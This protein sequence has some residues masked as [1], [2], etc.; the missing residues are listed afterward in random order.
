MVYATPMDTLWHNTSSSAQR[1]VLRGPDLIAFVAARAA[2]AMSSNTAARY[3]VA[4][5]CRLLQ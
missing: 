4:Y 3:V 5:N 1:Q 2:S